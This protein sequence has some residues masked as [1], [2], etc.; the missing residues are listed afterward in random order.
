M[1]EP[2]AVGPDREGAAELRD[3]ELLHLQAIARAEDVGV[4]LH[5]AGLQRAGAR[6]P[7]RQQLRGMHDGPCSRSPWNASS[8]TQIWSEPMACGCRSSDAGDGGGFGSC[9][10]G[11]WL[12]AARISGLVL[13]IGCKV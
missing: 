11:C 7:G 1:A 13:R 8:W 12:C 6:G 10:H 5:A 2:G 4:I 3:V 9:F